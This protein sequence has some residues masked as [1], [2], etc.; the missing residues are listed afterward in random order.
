MDTW[1]LANGVVSLMVALVLAGLV[2]HPDVHEGLL[3]KAG[4]IIMVFS[5]MAT[6]MLTFTGSVDW[7]AYWRAAFWLRVGLFAALIGALSRI[8]GVFGGP[9]R[10]I[11]DWFTQH[12]SPRSRH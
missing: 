4:L 6:A 9:R 3:T 8:L 5:L 2:L 1:H 7:G 10:R 12:D 11:D